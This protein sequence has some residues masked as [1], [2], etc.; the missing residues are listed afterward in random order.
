MRPPIS[1]ATLVKAGV[2]FAIWTG[3]G[4]LSAWQT[5]YWYSF[6]K[7]PMSWAESLSYE[8]SYA[9]LWAFCTPLILWLARRF[10]IE[11]NHWARNLVI[12]AVVMTL[13]IALIKTAFYSGPRNSDQA[14]S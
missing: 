7:T 1:R 9:W 4:A 8:V 14:I 5:H 11:R 6:T 3:Y 13:L 2:L 10:R 12:H